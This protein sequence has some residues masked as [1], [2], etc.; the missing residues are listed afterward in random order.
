MFFSHFYV[1]LYTAENYTLFRGK[2]PPRTI[3]NCLPRGTDAKADTFVNLLFM[4][5]MQEYRNVPRE[6]HPSLECM[7]ELKGREISRNHLK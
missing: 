3:R 7:Y 4:Y 2:Y 1:K 6:N 5:D